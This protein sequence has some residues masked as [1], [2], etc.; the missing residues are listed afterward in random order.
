LISPETPGAEVVRRL[1]TYYGKSKTGLTIK[2]L[3]L[4]KKDV[5]AALCD[6]GLCSWF[7]PLHRRPF[8]R[9]SYDLICSFSFSCHTP[10]NTYLA[11]SVGRRFFRTRRALRLLMGSC[12]NGCSYLRLK[13]G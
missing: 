2:D 11:A 8:P 13:V 3:G 9:N 6:T 5:Q 7:P 1:K 10:R 4:H 12:F